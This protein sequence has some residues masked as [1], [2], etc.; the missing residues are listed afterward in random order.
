MANGTPIVVYRSVNRDGETYALEP[1]S[2]VWL[3]ENFGEGLHMRARLFIAHE[4]H[5]HLKQVPR[6]LVNRI[7]PLLTGMTVEELGVD[8]MV[9]DPTTGQDVPV[10]A[11]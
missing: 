2:K 3:E 8:V 9:R 1:N 6:N 4:S 5:G 10:L 11:A 7:I